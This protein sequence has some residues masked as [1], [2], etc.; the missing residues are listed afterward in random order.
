MIARRRLRGQIPSANAAR[1]APTAA[2]YRDV[3]AHE[4]RGFRS[5]NGFASSV[6]R[7][8]RS[9]MKKRRR[10]RCKKSAREKDKATRRF[11][12]RPRLLL[13][14]VNTVYRMDSSSQHIPGPGHL[15]DLTYHIVIQAQAAACE[16]KYPQGGPKRR[17]VILMFLGMDDRLVAGWT[18][19]MAADWGTPFDDVVMQEFVLPRTERQTQSVA[20]GGMHVGI[21]WFIR[22]GLSGSHG[23]GR[24]RDE[25][26]EI[27]LRIRCW[28]H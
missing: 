25:Q 23:D 2:A 8:A 19:S 21:R 20:E 22:P 12:A 6:R 13:Q 5:R 7:L 27:R 1:L 26:G 24:T 3:N 17:D 11:A 15:P 16:Q 4:T 10:I 9:R 14:S 18:R 28:R